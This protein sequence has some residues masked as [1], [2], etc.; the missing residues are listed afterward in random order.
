VR[1]FSEP[2]RGRRQN[3]LRSRLCRHAKLL[4][5]GVVDREA[6]NDR[7]AAVLRQNSER[8]NDV[9]GVTQHHGS[10]FGNATGC[11]PQHVHGIDIFRLREVKARRHAGIAGIAPICVPA[12][13]EADF[14][15]GANGRIE[16]V[17]C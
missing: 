12:R 7:F 15:A 16:G 2:G 17:D 9:I 10:L 14:D 11:R 4:A 5:D 3:Q 6:Q 13:L 8:Q 1:A